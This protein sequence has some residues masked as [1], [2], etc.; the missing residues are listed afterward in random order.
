MVG[1]RHGL[2]SNTSTNGN[3]NSYGNSDNFNR[4]QRVDLESGYGTIN[5]IK[6]KQRFRDAIEHTLRDNRA[7][8]LKRK[9][10][11][12]IDHDALEVYRKSE[13]S[14][15]DTLGLAR[16]DADT[17]ATAQKH[18]EQKSTPVLRRA[19]PTSRRLGRSRHG[20]D[21]AGRRHC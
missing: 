1:G 14:V 18:K 5:K 17:V 9:L 2:L 7:N 6:P 11:H 3:V 21:I 12:Q 20:R 15:C 13:E 10:I 16:L 19:E 8:E 4:Y